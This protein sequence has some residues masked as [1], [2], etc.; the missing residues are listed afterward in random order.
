MERLE[1]SEYS[2]LVNSQHQMARSFVCIIKNPAKTVAV[3]WADPLDSDALSSDARVYHGLRRA[4]VPSR[5]HVDAAETSRWS[6]SPTQQ[7]HQCA[8]LR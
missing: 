8:C 5:S 1:C 2:Q 6:S 4:R 3:L 7:A